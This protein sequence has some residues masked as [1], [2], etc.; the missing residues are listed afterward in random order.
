MAT[1]EGLHYLRVCVVP[2][3]SPSPT[4]RSFSYVPFRNNRLV[5]GFHDAVLFARYVY[6][7]IRYMKYRRLFRLKRLQRTV[8][9][10]VTDRQAKESHAR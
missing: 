9:V 5:R 4:R 2:T 7:N 10:L 8:V 6:Y 3:T 1:D